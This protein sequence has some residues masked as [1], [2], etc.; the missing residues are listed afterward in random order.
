MSTNM[1]THPQLIFKASTATNSA[2]LDIW[3]DLSRQPFYLLLYLTGVMCFVGCRSIS[4]GMSFI[5]FSLRFR[6][7]HHL[8]YT[9]LIHAV[10]LG[11]CKAAD[12]RRGNPSVG[13]RD[14]HSQVVS[15]YGWNM[16]HRKT[17]TAPPSCP[18][19][20]FFEAR[21]VTHKRDIVDSR[22]TSSL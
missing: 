6:T 19:A 11:T 12:A 4:R 3:D 17:H 5:G 15:R 14:F 2:H 9:Q 22:D 21:D 18:S 13:F 20:P 7:Y 8:D 10:Q 1:S 16:N